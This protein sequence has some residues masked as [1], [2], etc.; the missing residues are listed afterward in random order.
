MNTAK[1]LKPDTNNDKGD[2]RI[3]EKQIYQMFKFMIIVDGY[4]HAITLRIHVRAS[5]PNDNTITI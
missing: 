3:S 4:A 5:C 2:G 1:K